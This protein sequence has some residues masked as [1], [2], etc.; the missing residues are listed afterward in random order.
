MIRLLLLRVRVLFFKELTQVIRDGRLRFLMIGPPVVQLI[1]FGYAAN[2]DLKNIQLA[3]YDEDRTPMSR[4]LAFSFSSS[5]YF[6]VVRHISSETE[7]VRLIDSSEV[8]AVLHLGPGLAGKVS[9][10]RTALVQIVVAGTNSN[11]AALV[12]SYSA[13]I[14]EGFNRSRLKERLEKNPALAQVLPAGASG[15]VQVEVRVWYNDNLVSRNFYVPGIIAMVIMLTTLNLTSMAVVREKEVGTMEQI[16]AS[17]IKPVEFIL[18]KT[19]PFGLIGVCQAALVTTVGI[20]WFGVP[21][22]GSLALLFGCLL[23]YLLTCLSLGLMISTVSRTQQQA[24]VTT[25]MFFFPAILLSGF[26][27]PIANMPPEIQMITYA[28]PLRYFLIII[29]GIFLKGAG[30]EILWPHMLALLTIGLTVMVIAV[31]RVGKTLD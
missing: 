25:F 17:P 4:D 29:R 2:L 18:G 9:S 21:M 20:F 7:M 10:G 14:I 13:Q 16:M 28:N 23:I 31:R 11:T 1:A 8:K 19:L 3:I 30:L 26:M 6:K 27:F 12:Q 15:V 22:R 5:G 24:L